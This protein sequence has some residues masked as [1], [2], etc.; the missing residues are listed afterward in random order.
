MPHAHCNLKC[1]DN[2]HKLQI[3]Y[4]YMQNCNVLLIVGPSSDHI[5][6]NNSASV[7]K[8]QRTELHRLGLKKCNKYFR[9]RFQRY[10]N[11]LPA[12]F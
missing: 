1:V 9:V 3:T 10:K 4:F 2:T 5:E 7:S 6:K 12:F 11:Q 8:T